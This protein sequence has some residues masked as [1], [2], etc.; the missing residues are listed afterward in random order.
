[1]A[2]AT[3]SHRY[4]LVREDGADFVTYQTSSGGGVWQ[5]ISVW[6]IPQHAFFGNKR[7]GA[8]G[9]KRCRFFPISKTRRTAS[10]L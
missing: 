9:D 6:M 2:K 8:V 7:R 5:T 3:N 1:M 10:F 4:K